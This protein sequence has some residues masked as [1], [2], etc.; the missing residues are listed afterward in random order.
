MLDRREPPRVAGEPSSR[1]IARVRNALALITVVA[2]LL[3]VAA[4]FKRETCGCGGPGVP[5]GT[6]AVG[7]ALV[8]LASLGAYAAISRRRR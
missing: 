3:A 2:A 7:A 5:Y 1:P 8:A 4:M 6:I